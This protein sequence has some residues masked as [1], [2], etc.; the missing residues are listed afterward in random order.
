MM[1]LAREVIPD[2]VPKVVEVNASN[3]NE[4]K[5]PYMVLEWPSGNSMASCWAK[6]AATHFRFHKAFLESPRSIASSLSDIKEPAN[7]EY[8][9]QM[10]D[11]ATFHLGPTESQNPNSIRKEEWDA[12]VKFLTGM[13]ET[14]SKPKPDGLGWFAPKRQ[15]SEPY[16]LAHTNLNLPNIYVDGLSQVCTIVGWED[17]QFVP[18][19]PGHEAHPACLMED[20]ALRHTD[21]DRIQ[22]SAKVFE[23]LSLK[24][25]QDRWK[26]IVLDYNLNRWKNIPPSDNRWKKALFDSNDSGDM[27]GA[28]LLAHNLSLAW[29]SEPE[30]PIQRVQEVRTKL[31]YSGSD[32]FSNDNSLPRCLHNVV[33][34]LLEPS[35]GGPREK[36]EAGS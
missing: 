21:E 25:L 7:G 32:I 14:I 29:Q 24:E 6:R 15:G 3:E 20:W 22:H 19:I 26:N 23:K 30:L 5:A 2:N 33:L 36:K 9:S 4:L 27:P 28:S 11:G 18:A 34:K 8:E 17:A 31:L 1:K 35:H 12:G 13:A 10:K 16:I